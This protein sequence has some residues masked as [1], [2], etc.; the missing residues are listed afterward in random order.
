MID[1]S[2]V[3]ERWSHDDAIDTH[4]R[5]SPFLSSSVLLENKAENQITHFVMSLVN[6]ENLEGKLKFGEETSVYFLYVLNVLT[7]CE[8][9]IPTHFFIPHI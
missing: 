3:N 1:A 4:L 2:A 6:K 9:K 7:S 5:S 8:G